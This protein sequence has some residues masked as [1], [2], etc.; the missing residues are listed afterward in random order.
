MVLTM[1]TIPLVFLIGSSRARTGE[2]P[3]AALE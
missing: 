1:A 2:A 3:A